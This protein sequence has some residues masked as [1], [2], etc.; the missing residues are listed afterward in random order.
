MNRA[1]GGRAAGGVSREEIN[2][3]PEYKNRPRSDTDSTRLVECF[4]SSV[5]STS[6]NNT[7]ILQ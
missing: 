6:Y 7:L 3:L 2:L 5:M 4:I 1:E